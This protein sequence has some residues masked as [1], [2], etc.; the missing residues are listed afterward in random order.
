VEGVYLA[1]LDQVHVG[2][3]LWLGLFTFSLVYLSGLSL[4]IDILCLFCP[5]LLSIVGLDYFIFASLPLIIISL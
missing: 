5:L 2:F 4:S 1:G 3:R